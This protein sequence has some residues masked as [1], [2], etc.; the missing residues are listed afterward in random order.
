MI[1]AI[2]ERKRQAKQNIQLKQQALLT[3][4]IQCQTIFFEK[5]MKKSK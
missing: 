3:N 5:T 4:K 1:F 2:M